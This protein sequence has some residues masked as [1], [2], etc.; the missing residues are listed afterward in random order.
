MTAGKDRQHASV[1]QLVEQLLCKRQ[2]A[3][4]RP[5]G[6]SNCFITSPFF[7]LFSATGRSNRGGFVVKKCAKEVRK[8]GNTNSA[9][10]QQ[11]NRSY[12]KKR[13]PATDEECEKHV[14]A[15]EQRWNGWL[16]GNRIV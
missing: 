10:N 2:V 1:A 11:I 14:P 15:K 6:S 4:S 16:S 5:A 7:L 12:A 3:G 13:K 8:Y 9:E